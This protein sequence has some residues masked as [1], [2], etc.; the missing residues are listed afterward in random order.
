MTTI[1]GNIATQLALTLI[2]VV[3]T[4][5]AWCATEIPGPPQEQPIAI[6]HATVHP[7]STPP[8]DDATVLFDQGRIVRVGR[9]VELPPGTQVVDARGKHVYPGL[10]N[11]DG[12]LGLL[13]INAVRATVDT[14][15]VG[16]IN[17]NVRAEV[18]VNP[19]SEL[20]PVTRSGGVLLN[21]TTP[22]SG[23]LAGTSAILQLDG[24]TTEE[25]TLKSR[26]GMHL[27]WPALVE[28]GD[29][30]DHGKDEEKHDDQLRRIEELF[31]Q[32][33][34][35]HAARTRNTQLPV[36]LRWESLR[37]VLSGDVPLIVSA[38]RAAQ[39]QSAVAFASRR[40]LRLIIYEGFD[41]AECA[42]LL[43][44]QDVPVIVAGVYRLPL[45]RHEAYDEAFTL[46][47]R[48]KKAKVRFC[49][50]GS[51]RF[52]AANIRNLPY[53]AAMAIAFG[54]PREDALRAIT[55]S[56]AEMLGVADRVGSLEVGKDATLI[57]TD[58]DVFD[59]ATHVVQ[60]FIQGRHVD[61]SDRHKRLY[62]KYQAR[63]QQVKESP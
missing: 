7:V 47:A 62:R 63:L 14:S 27:Q 11:T 22:Q 26:A 36:D 46:P 51:A 9:N 53:H 61:L 6:T 34:D 18:A 43:R 30:D 15:E 4:R 8:V 23:I 17:P 31:D 54:L 16:S 13:E 55:L 56:P 39:I 28:S 44:S 24:W 37:P 19:D 33:A 32:A 50:A 25:L 20:I 29:H 40:K 41:A 35:Y 45:R 3:G 48:L 1:H 12:V 2:F 38:R 10:F 42:G 52:D 58:G 59:T 57:V 5:P 49:I 21:L 60:A